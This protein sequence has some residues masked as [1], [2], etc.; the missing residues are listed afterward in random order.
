MDFKQIK[1]FIAVADLGNV[2]KAAEVL[3]VVQPA[4][5]R[6]I[7]LL[8]EDLGFALFTRERH[9]MVI[10]TH[11]QTML[12]HARRALLELDKARAEITGAASGGPSGLVTVGLLPSSINALASSLVAAVK[13]QYPGI[14]LRLVTGY[15]GNLLQWL[16]NGEI[17]AA[18]LYEVEHAPNIQTQLMIEEPLWVVAPRA[19]KLNPKKPMSLADL[20]HH[21]VVLPSASHGIRALV[22]HACAV[23][24]QILNIVAETNALSVQS[25]L[26][27]GGQGLTIL[28]PMAVADELLSKRLCGTPLGDPAI[29]RTIVMALPA[30]TAT[31]RHVDA[32]VQALMA[33]AREI[34][35][36]GQW[37]HGRWV[38]L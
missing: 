9:G 1:A 23:S 10:T 6:Q 36:S 17:D 4:V 7:K 22:D 33:C 27:L 14:Q 29:K 15:A 8:E 16:Q 24:G 18:M 3:H 28:P 34:T 20:A 13:T 25:S 12:T 37:L 35:F 21:P 11:G 26:V 2:T 19:F 31:P 32:V 5:S 30:T 38:G